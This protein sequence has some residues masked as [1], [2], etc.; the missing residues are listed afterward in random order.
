MATEVSR[1]PLSPRATSPA[2][3]GVARL[4][5]RGYDVD[6]RCPCGAVI[7]P[8]ALRCRPCN[9]EAIAPT[10]STAE[11]VRNLRYQGYDRDQIASLLGVSAR[12]VRRYWSRAPEQ[13][14]R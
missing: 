14:V 2:E 10:R 3:R 9:A 7:G 13:R 11:R 5:E 12:T 4:R 1:F 8:G 6:N